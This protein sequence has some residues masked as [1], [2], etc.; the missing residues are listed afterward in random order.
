MFSVLYGKII[1]GMKILVVSQYFWP[2][3]FRIND[4]CS[5]LQKRGH[6]L[7][8][9]TGIP[10]YPEGK[11]FQSFLDRPDDFKF[12]DNVEI[13]RVPISPRKSGKL[14]LILNYITYFISGIFIGSWKLR[15]KNFDMIFVC[16]LSPATVAL[17]A[18]FIGKIKKIPIAMWILDLWPDSLKAV[19]VIKNKFLLFIIQVL[20]NFIYRRCSIIFVQSMS[21][22]VK[23]SSLINHSRKVLYIPNWAENYFVHNNHIKELDFTPSNNFTVT[24]AGNIGLA[25]DMDCVINA[26]K[27]LN[28]NHNIEIR[29][30]GDGSDASRVLKLIKINKLQ[31]K[32]KMLG[33]HPLKAMP[34]FFLESDAMLITLSDQEI[35]SMT[36]PGKLQSYMAIAKPVI[37][38]INGEARQVIEKSGVGYCVASG[39]YE[40]LADAILKI[41]R[42]SKEQREVMGENGKKFYF[43]EFERQ[44]IIDN[45][46]EHLRT[47]I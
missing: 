38:A 39:D 20:M 22:K 1:K 12:Y 33:R 30:I 31:D 5:E 25:Q 14:A 23:V 44:I 9:L 28:N 3:N 24:F 4:L 45:F 34:K 47:L 43:K 35:F 29:L 8:V 15:N 41:S 40:G 16:Q 26:A 6:K 11:T 36:I 13:I 32:V 7:T 37:G 10:N 17:P 2:E 18:I 27:L 19:G 42:L 46:E 21:F